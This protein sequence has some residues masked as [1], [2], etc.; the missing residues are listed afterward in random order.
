MVKVNGNLVRSGIY[1]EDKRDDE[2]VMDV[3]PYHAPYHKSQLSPSFT[4]MVFF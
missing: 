3:D 4:R 2:R 1:R